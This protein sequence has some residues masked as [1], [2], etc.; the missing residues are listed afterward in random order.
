MATI[1]TFIALGNG[2]SGTVKTLNLNFKAKFV[3]VERTNEKSP[4]FRILAGDIEFGEAWKKKSERGNEYL[5]VKMDD[6]NLANPI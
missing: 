4:D 2:F 1:G 5:S 6:P 3:P